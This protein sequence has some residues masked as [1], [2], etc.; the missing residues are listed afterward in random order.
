MLR[1]FTNIGFYIVL[2]AM[3]GLLCVHGY[4]GVQSTPAPPDGITSNGS[5]MVS[6]AFDTAG[7]VAGAEP[8]S[9]IK[10]ELVEACLGG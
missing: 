10:L 7:I 3:V 9:P 6:E 2:M 5:A 4:Q 1:L 8:H